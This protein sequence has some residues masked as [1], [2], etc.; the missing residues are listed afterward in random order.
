MKSVTYRKIEAKLTEAEDL[1][2][3]QP[4]FGTKA[5]QIRDQLSDLMAAVVA[6]RIRAELAESESSPPAKIGLTSARVFESKIGHCCGQHAFGVSK[7][8]S[9]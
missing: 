8:G 2:V 5:F 3:E 7:R 1:F 6:E 9:V 4:L